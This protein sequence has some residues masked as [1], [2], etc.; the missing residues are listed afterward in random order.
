MCIDSYGL[1]AA[2]YYTAP[3]MFNHSSLDYYYSYIIRLYLIYLL[4]HLFRHGL[5]RCF[6]TDE[7]EARVVR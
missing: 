4:T 3:G 7:C 1:D 6:K 5:G 2:H